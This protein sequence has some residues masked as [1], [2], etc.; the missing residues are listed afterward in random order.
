MT[1][2]E[3]IAIAETILDG[4]GLN[5]VQELIIRQCWEGRCSY[6]EIAKLSKYDEYIKSVAAK[7]WKQFSDAFGEKVKKNNLQSVFQ[8]Y[9]RRKQIRLQQSRLIEVNLSGASLS[10][11]GLSVANL[12]GAK[13]FTNLSETDLCQTDLGKSQSPASN[14][15]LTHESLQSENGHNQGIQSNSE[16]KIYYWNDLR[17]RSPEQVK[18]AEALDRA[19]ILFFPNSKARLTTPQGRQNQ[20]PDFLIFHQGK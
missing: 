8:R 16:E 12:S 1:V 4:E 18:I 17:F 9:I 20:E 3:A 15:E 11:A 5:D 14:T 10:G 6:E 19:S 2:D 13:L 7:L